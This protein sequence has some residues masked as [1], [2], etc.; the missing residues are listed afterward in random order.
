MDTRSKSGSV[1]LKLVL[2]V[3]LILLVIF[4]VVMGSNARKDCDESKI[5]AINGANEYYVNNECD[6]LCVDKGY[7]GGGILRDCATGYITTCDCLCTRC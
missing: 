2:V 6:S 5:S 1:G 7:P 3:A 4:I